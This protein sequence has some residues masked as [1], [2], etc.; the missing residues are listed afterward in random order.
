M[1]TIESSVF[2]LVY[3]ASFVVAIVVTATLSWSYAGDDAGVT[4]QPSLFPSIAFYGSM[5]IVAGLPTL[6]V[7]KIYRKT[8]SWV[9]LGGVFIFSAYVLGV[10]ASG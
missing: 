1:R 2:V 10:V 9:F 8:G 3:L 6:M 5:A 7:V 4:N